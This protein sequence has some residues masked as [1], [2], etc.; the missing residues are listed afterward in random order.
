[1]GDSKNNVYPQ[2][3]AGKSSPM[4]GGGLLVE[5]EKD[6]M[7]STA[8][9]PGPFSFAELAGRDFIAPVSHHVDARSHS[10]AWW[11]FLKTPETESVALRGRLSF[12]L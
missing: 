9:H 5:V 6:A 2:N 12:S 4:A 10:P 11:S 1:M 7:D 8:Y 3:A